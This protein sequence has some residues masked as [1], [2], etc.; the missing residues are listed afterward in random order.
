MPVLATLQS[1]NSTYKLVEQIV[2]SADDAQPRRQFAFYQS[3]SSISPDTW[4]DTRE[5]LMQLADNY[6]EM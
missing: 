5:S 3:T 2:R 6:S 4:S 1:R